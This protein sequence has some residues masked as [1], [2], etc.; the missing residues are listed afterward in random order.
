MRGRSAETVLPCGEACLLYRSS[1]SRA[2]LTLLKHQNPCLGIKD[3]NVV[4]AVHLQGQQ[5]GCAFSYVS[6]RSVCDTLCINLFVYEGHTFEY[7]VNLKAQNICMLKAK[8]V[9]DSM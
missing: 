4:E 2:T 8:I 5:H 9:I 6:A 1:P 3:M 7:F